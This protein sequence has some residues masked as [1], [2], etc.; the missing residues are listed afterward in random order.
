MST[1]VTVLS[2]RWRQGDESALD[3]AMPL[4]YDEL[5]RIARTFLP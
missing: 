5:R 3:A 2:H 4:V 1:E